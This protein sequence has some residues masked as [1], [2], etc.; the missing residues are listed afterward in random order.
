MDAIREAAH[1]LAEMRRNRGIAL[2]QIAASTKICMYY[3]RAIESGELGKLPAGDFYRKSYLRQ[4]AAALGSAAGDVL[5]HYALL[6]AP[7][8]PA[9]PPESPFT[10]RV[11][12]AALVF[13]SL[14]AFVSKAEWLVQD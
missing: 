12:E 7:A 4:Y 11:H 5:T 9:E 13:R 6:S 14:A 8:S 2:E 10:R 1:A 3:L